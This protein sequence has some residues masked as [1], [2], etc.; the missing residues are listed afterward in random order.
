MEQEQNISADFPFAS[1]YKEVL[2][3]KIHYI[4]EGQ[5]DPIVFIHGVPTSS[6]LWR[7]I[8]SPLSKHHRCIALDLIGYGQSDKPD[9]EYSV[10]DHLSYFEGFMQALGLEKVTLVMHAWGSILGFDY[11]M[12]HPDKIH[13]LAFMESQLRPIKDWRMLSLPVKQFAQV[14]SQDDGGY[15]AIVEQNLLVERVLPNAIMRRLTQEE[16]NHYRAP[17]VDIEHRKS[18]WGFVHEVPLGDGQGTA[19][20]VIEGYSEAL[21]ASPIPKL[22]VYGIPGFAT[23]IETIA[24]AKESLPKLSVVDVG[25]A[26]HYPQETHPQAISEALHDWLESI[27]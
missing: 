9:L 5:G 6:Y 8:I 14:L 13:G 22:L 23:T 4:D 21:Q 19:Q 27:E 18:L 7:N 1:H 17:F 12:K 16:M 25:E 15:S 24:W 20:D 3:H 11:A 10:R 2:G 26:L